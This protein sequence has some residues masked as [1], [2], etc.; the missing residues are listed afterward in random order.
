MNSDFIEQ[1]QSLINAIYPIYPHKK[2]SSGDFIRCCKYFLYTPRCVRLKQIR[3][4]NFWILNRW[5]L[6]GGEILRHPLQFFSFKVTSWCSEFNLLLQQSSREGFIT[7]RLNIDLLLYWKLKT[8]VQ[9]SHDVKPVPNWF[10][11]FLSRPGFHLKFL[12]TTFS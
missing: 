6:D 2:R 1:N 3:R 7:S 11:N 10:T 9:S 4:I 8:G 5:G 12:N